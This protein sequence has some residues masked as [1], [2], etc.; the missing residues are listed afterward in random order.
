MFSYISLSVSSAAKFLGFNLL[1][2]QRTFFE[3]K[4]N[5]AVEN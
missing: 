2:M 5:I 1:T 4:L 3:A